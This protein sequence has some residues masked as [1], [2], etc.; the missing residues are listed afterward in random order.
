AAPATGAAAG[1]ACVVHALRM[2]H[3]HTPEALRDPLLWILHAGYAWLVLGLGLLALGGFGLFD[4]RLAVHALTAG[5]IGSMTL[6]MIC[7]V[8]LGHTGRELRAGPWAAAAFCVMQAAAL[9]RVFGPAAW[10][11]GAAACIAG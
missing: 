9:L 1:A 10:P 5:S 2:R 3:Y 4:H 11:A 6:G 7:R 8:T